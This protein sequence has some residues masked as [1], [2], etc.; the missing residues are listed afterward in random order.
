MY[1]R[2]EIEVETEDGSV[3]TL[4][5]YILDNFRKEAFI[6]ERT[7]LFNEYTEKNG[8]YGPYRPKLNDQNFDINDFL[9]KIKNNV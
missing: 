4:K 7:V 6:H 3:E 9:K 1:S 8:I 5:T 2:F